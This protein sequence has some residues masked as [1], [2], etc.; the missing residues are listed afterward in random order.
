MKQIVLPV[1]IFLLLLSVAG[2]AQYD[3]K[4]DF[5]MFCSGCHPKGGNTINPAKSLR[6]MDREANGIKKSADIVRVMRKPGAGMRAYTRQDIPDKR[7]RAIADYIL[8][9][10]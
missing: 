9:T 4:A 1:I 7:A 3:G 10:F 6:K 2:G 5:E 8:K